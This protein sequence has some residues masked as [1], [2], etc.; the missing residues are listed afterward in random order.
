MYVVSGLSHKR[1]LA[2]S[3]CVTT[4]GILLVDHGSRSAAANETLREIAE[5]VARKAEGAVVGFAHME[6]AAPTIPEGLAELVRRGAGEVV[7]VPYF[8]A[9]G[10]HSTEDIPRL[11][12]EAMRAHP[13]IAHRVAAPLGVHDLLAELVLERARGA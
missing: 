8:L 10:R 11:V 12:G 1:R 2:H 9:P 7:V 6:L 3:P 4:R 13:R 5:R